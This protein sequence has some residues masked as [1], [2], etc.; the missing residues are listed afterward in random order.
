MPLI[1][2]EI[3]LTLSLRVLREILVAHQQPI[4]QGHCKLKEKLVDAVAELQE[5]KDIKHGI[6][7]L[8]KTG[9]EKSVAVSQKISDLKR[10]DRWTLFRNVKA[11]GLMEDILRKTGKKSL[12]HLSRKDVMKQLLSLK[13]MPPLLEP[14]HSDINKKKEKMPRPTKIR[15]EEHDNELYLELFDKEDANLS[16]NRRIKNIEN[17]FNDQASQKRESSAL[18]QRYYTLKNRNNR[19]LHDPDYSVEAEYDIKEKD[20]IPRYIFLYSFLLNYR[21]FLNTRKR[22][23]QPQ[24]HWKKKNDIIKVKNEVSDEE[25]GDEVRIIDQKEY[26]QGIQSKSAT[27]VNYPNGPPAKKRKLNSTANKSDSLTQSIDL[28]E[29]VRRIGYQQ[30]VDILRPAFEEDGVYDIADLK[31]VDKDELKKYGVK[32][33]SHRKD[34]IAKIQRL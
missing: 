21:Q 12:K 33:M 8:K 6:A 31:S 15:W 7:A 10:M 27:S 2:R 4:P 26:A 23:K 5:K 14:L 17:A 22:R 9:S 1:P 19:D 3:L 20:I 28:D 11:M 24:R 34:M 30:Y 29:D 13:N 16:I 32:K 25:S 18:L